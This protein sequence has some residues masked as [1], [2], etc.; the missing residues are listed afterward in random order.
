MDNI[1]IATHRRFI[2]QCDVSQRWTATY[3]PAE[4]QTIEHLVY[5]GERAASGVVSARRAVPMHVW[6]A[7]HVCIMELAEPLADGLKHKLQH[8][9]ASPLTSPM[10]QSIGDFLSESSEVDN[11]TVVGRLQ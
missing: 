8:A 2:H 10:I 3:S 6:Q 9:I 4:G 7:C 5:K 1:R 11:S